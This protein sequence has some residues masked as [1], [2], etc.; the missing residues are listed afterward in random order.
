MWADIDAVVE[1][2]ERDMRATDREAFG[3]DEVPGLVRAAVGRLTAPPP[4][5][6]GPHLPHPDRFPIVPEDVLREWST[7]ERRAGGRC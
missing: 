2:L 3:P 4:G 5:A 6:S 7:R 1:Q